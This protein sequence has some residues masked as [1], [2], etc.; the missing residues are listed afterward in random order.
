MEKN[1]DLRILLGRNIKRYRKHK[2]FSQEQLAEIIGVSVKHLSTIEN[3]SAFISADL[4]QR[5]AETLDVDVYKL[6][7]DGPLFQPPFGEEKNK[8]IEN[9]IDMQV[10]R[11]AE[12]I[13]KI[14]TEES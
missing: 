11:A 3:G 14:I 7:Y 4:L 13:K 5:L 12:T 1:E 6:F 9:L 2:G 8:Q 10:I